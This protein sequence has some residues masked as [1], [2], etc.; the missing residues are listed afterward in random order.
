MFG[1]P[2]SWKQYVEDGTLIS[3]SVEQVT[4][5]MRELI[6]KLRIG[7][8]MMLQ[9]FGDLGRD[10]TMMN[11][12]LFAEKV[13]PELKDL[14]DDEWED[15]WWIKPLTEAQTAVPAAVS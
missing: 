10:A 12:R 15:R 6:K 11:T 8:L 13:M 5:R 1:K 3:G 2:R 14:W 4:E 7:H 9:Q